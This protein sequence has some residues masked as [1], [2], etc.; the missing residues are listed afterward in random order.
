[1]GWIP[2]PDH[3]RY[4]HLY[5]GI[6]GEHGYG[7]RCRSHY[8]SWLHCMEYHGPSISTVYRSFNIPVYWNEYS[9]WDDILRN[10]RK[11]FCI[12]VSLIMLGTIC[13]SSSPDRSI[14]V[15]SECALKDTDGDGRPDEFEIDQ[16]LDE[17]ENDVE[18]TF[19]VYCCGDDVPDGEKTGTLLPEMWEFIEKLTWVGSTDDITIVVQFDGTDQLNGNHQDM[20]WNDIPNNQGRSHIAGSS[21]RRFLVGRDSKGW[22]PSINLLEDCTNN[23][24]IDLYDVTDWDPRNT[25]KAHSSLNWEANMADPATF[26]EFIS[27]GIDTF[28]S[29]NYCLYVDSHGDGIHGFGYDHRPDQEPTTTIKDVLNLSEIGTVAHLL[30]REDPPKRLDMVMLQSCLMGNIEFCYEF[31]KFSDYY[32]ASENVMHLTGNQ[33]DEVLKQLV[34]NPSWTPSRLAREFIDIEYRYS[35][36]G[37]TDPPWNIMDWDGKEKLTL[38]CLNNTF[39]A[40][41]DLIDQIGMMNHVLLEG[42]SSDPGWYIPNLR[43]SI[44]TAFTDHYTNEFSY[45]Q[46][47]YY[48]FLQFWNDVCGPRDGI[49]PIL[50]NLSRNISRI[51]WNMDLG[52]RGIEYEKHDQTYFDLTKGLSI[53]LPFSPAEWQLA[54]PEYQH[55][56]FNER[57]N[58]GTV[59]DLLHDNHPPI[60]N[61][62]D[63][64][65]SYPEE[66]VYCAFNATDLNGD[67]VDMSIEWTDAPFSIFVNWPL[68]I[69]FIATEEQVGTYHARLRFD[70]RNG[71][72]SIMEVEMEV[73]PFNIPPMIEPVPPQAAYA[74]EEFTYQLSISDDNTEDV[75]SVSGKY[76]ENGSCWIDDGRVLHVMPGQDDI[77]RGVV[78]VF[79]SD[80]NGSEVNMRFPINVYLRNFP[81]S[82]P[83]SLEFHIEAGD[84]E[85][86][87]VGYTDRDGDAIS[88][89]DGAWWPDWMEVSLEDELVLS[90]HPKNGD[91]ANWMFSIRIID[92]KGGVL[93]VNISIEVVSP[94]APTLMLSDRMTIVERGE[95]RFDLETDYMGNGAVRY[96]IH[97]GE[98]EFIAIINNSLVLT[99]HDGD[100]GAYLL[101]VRTFIVG[102]SCSISEHTIHVE[103]N[104]STL[105]VNVRID[106]IKGVYLVGDTVHV[107]VTYSGYGSDLRLG[108]A[109][110][111]D[112]EIVSHVNGTRASFVLFNVSD[113]V[114]LVD[115]DYPGLHVD[116]VK[117]Q[118]EEREDE[119][120]GLNSSPFLL[121]LMIM[122]VL[123]CVVVA[124][125]VLVRKRSGKE[126]DIP[127]SYLVD[128]RLGR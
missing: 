4:R 20:F 120:E 126:R 82:G 23:T 90:L 31:S 121:V 69:S 1:M 33:D 89:E 96:E 34:E 67:M 83:D 57:T 78:E 46:I 41:T 35:R 118:V 64:I 87:Y 85:V 9:T 48:H 106:P 71:S 8:R 123:S 109:F 61:P 32:I 26:H 12:A 30:S 63:A 21:T 128:T 24:L 112:G 7:M 14:F 17:A 81:P 92:G 104:F 124:A 101:K 19:L 125:I 127:N 65:S 5:V 47:D 42:A 53:Y 59:V 76:S 68:S 111:E 105:E 113:V 18:W 108:L 93:N 43:S 73:I 100:Q 6:I 36:D 66:W 114:I 117:I 45:I 119:E 122:M 79:V 97:S 29:D 56:T 40:G 13:Y 102:G 55:S 37:M 49:F 95:Y 58:W 50:Q 103:Y 2:E 70:D 22:D 54:K 86:R 15:S 94:P 74:D 75:L 27:W 116:P 80:N 91:L 44:S 110:L 38:S 39:M 11:L 98:N 115:H 10:G 107:E 60:I 77:G 52:N 88:I 72:S 25:G 84:V 16:G 28:P 51:L 99:P 62:V 3:N